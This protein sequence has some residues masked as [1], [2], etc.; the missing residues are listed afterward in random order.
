MG[1]A[2]LRKTSIDIIKQNEIDK[3]KSF[4][5]ARNNFTGISNAGSSSLSGWSNER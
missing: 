1:K 3:K 4:G 2:K 5:I